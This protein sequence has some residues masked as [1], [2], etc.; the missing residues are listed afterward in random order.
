MIKSR[1]ISRLYILCFYIVFILFFTPTALYSQNKI[2]SIYRA[3]E[4][5]ET[6]NAIS[7]IN[8]L[9]NTFGDIEKK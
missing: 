8:N 7:E 6:E 1:Q 2:Q 3:I 9:E 4:N 5:G